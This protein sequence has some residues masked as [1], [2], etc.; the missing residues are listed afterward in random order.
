MPISQLNKRSIVPTEKWSKS[1]RFGKAQKR[2]NA[3]GLDFIYSADHAA[4]P[5]G[6]QIVVEEYCA[7]GIVLSYAE[8]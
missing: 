5:I 2:H 4:E 7:T 8:I 6:V 1:S 3:I